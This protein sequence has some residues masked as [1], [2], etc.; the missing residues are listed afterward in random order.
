MSEGG[1][2]ITMGSLGKW[3]SRGDGGH[4]MDRRVH[5]DG[6]F[7]DQGLYAGRTFGPAHGVGGRCTPSSREVPV[8]ALFSVGVGKPV[9]DLKD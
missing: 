2:R 4:C 9:K 1:S 8:A 5:V 3:T 6:F 7:G